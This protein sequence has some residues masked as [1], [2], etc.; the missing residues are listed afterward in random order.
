MGAN[1]ASPI[2]LAV[3]TL[4]LYPIESRA[5]EIAGIILR[6]AYATGISLTVMHE[7]GVSVSDPLFRKGIEFLLRTQYKD[8]WWFV[9]TRAFPL[10]PR[11]EGGYPFGINQ[12]I[13]AG[14]VSWASLAISYTPSDSSGA[15]I[16]LQVRF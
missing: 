13:S 16:N 3:R 2:A 11:F 4:N 6:L 10:Q 12:W 1:I 7:A 14:G 5:K 9:S 15:P 8:G